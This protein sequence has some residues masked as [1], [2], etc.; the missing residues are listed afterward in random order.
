MAIITSR[1]TFRGKEC[2]CRLATNFPVF[3]LQV[4]ESPLQVRS[5][6]AGFLL[7]LDCFQLVLKLLLLFNERCTQLRCLLQSA[8][9]LR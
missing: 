9:R 5:D 7:L 6:L 4:H 1:E 8:L 3:S 2:P